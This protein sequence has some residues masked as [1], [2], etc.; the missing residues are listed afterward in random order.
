MSDISNQSRYLDCL[1]A[2]YNALKAEIARRA[3]LQRVVLG[4]YIVVGAVILRDISSGSASPILVAYLWIASPLTLLFYAMENREIVHLGK[5]FREVLGPSAAE[6]TGQSPEKIFPSEIN[7]GGADKEERIRYN[8][9]LAWVIFFVIPG[10]ATLFYASSIWG[11]I[12]PLCDIAMQNAIVAIVIGIG[13][14]S[15]LVLLKREV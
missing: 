9:I 10:L 12:K 5:L 13:A 4:A 8:R 6:V 3:N 2:D 14:I 11:T 15:V 1:L 7:D